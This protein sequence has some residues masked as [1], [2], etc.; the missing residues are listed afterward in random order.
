MREEFCIA[1]FPNKWAV[2]EA[3]Y[4]ERVLN[5]RNRLITE[6]AKRGEEPNLDF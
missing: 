6:R 1:Q 3:L 2:Q 4:A 5:M